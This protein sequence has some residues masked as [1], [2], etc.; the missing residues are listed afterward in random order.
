MTKQLKHESLK[1]SELIENYRSGK[2]VIP[3]FQRDY[4][5]KPSKAALLIDSLYQGFPISSLLLWQSDEMVKARPNVP[6]P[7]RSSQVNWLIDGQQRVRTL[8]KIFTGE[9]LEVV[10]HPEHDQ[11]RLANAA[12]RND[13][14]WLRVADIWD[15]SVYRQLRRSFDGGSA[16]DKWEK[17]LEAVRDILNY[18]VPAVCMSGHSFDQAVDV[19]ERINTQGSK[20]KSEDIQSAKVAAKHTGFIA[21]EVVP[22]LATLRSSGFSRMNVMHLFRAC[23]FVAT[24]DGR[25]KTPLHELERK[26]INDAWKKTKT[27]TEQAIGLIRSELGL[28]NMDILWSGSLLV[29]LIAICARQSPRERDAKGM[30]GWLALAALSH[31]Y[32]GSSETALDQDLLACKDADPIRAL[33]KNLKDTRE[34]LKANPSDFAGAL[35]D[36]SGLLALFIACKHRGLFDFFS[37]AKIL[38]QGNVDKHHVLPRGQFLEQHR[39]GSDNLANIAFIS[40]E[41]NKSLGLT[42]PEVY[43]K[44]I[45]SKVLK[46][47]CIPMDESLWRIDASVEFWEQRKQLL[48][49]A[50]NDFIRASLPDRR[51]GLGLSS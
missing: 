32:S 39:H 8:E 48:A 46:S 38:S 11:F 43:L 20:L 27:A 40:A 10:F 16:I 35:A 9:E 41:A 4:V 3:E 33:L 29:P 47:Q 36:R 44:K 22:F 42:G 50:F 2:I 37:G 18:E 5:W 21:N 26:E 7:S 13:T 15:D 51:L 6:T 30:M 19:F 31:R 25:N 14:K 34:S 24:P 1:I 28:F 49:A 12:T 23:A 45:A 17:K